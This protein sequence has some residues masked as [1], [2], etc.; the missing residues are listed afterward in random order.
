M[1][2][3]IRIDVLCRV[4]PID[5]PKCRTESRHDLGDEKTYAGGNHT[6]DK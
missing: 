2:R 6:Q 5:M 3:M 4:I 1:V